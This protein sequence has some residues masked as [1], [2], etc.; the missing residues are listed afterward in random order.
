M[1]NKINE[2]RQR[3]KNVPLPDPATRTPHKTGHGVRQIENR[4][5]T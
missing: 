4:L 1:I 5:I 2:E 3:L